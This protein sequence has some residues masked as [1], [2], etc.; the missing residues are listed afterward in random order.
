MFKNILFLQFFYMVILVTNAANVYRHQITDNDKMYSNES[1]IKSKTII[2]SII[3]TKVTNIT[4]FPVEEYKQHDTEYSPDQ[5]YH[6]V[7]VEYSPN[8]DYHS[9]EIKYSPDQTH[10]D[11]IEYERLNMDV[12][13]IQPLDGCD[14]SDH[15]TLVE[16][17]CQKFKMCASGKLIILSCPNELIFDPELKICNFRENVNGPCGNKKQIYY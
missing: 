15:L 4:Y 9:V 17:D 11:M 2:S 6:D 14:Y 3:D 12:N 7:E 1:P 13:K 16:Y 8:Q 10:D 5:E